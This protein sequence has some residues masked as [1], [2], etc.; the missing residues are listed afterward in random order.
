MLMMWTAAGESES[1]PPTSHHCETNLL[2]NPAMMSSKCNMHCLSLRTQV[3]LSSNQPVVDTQ[4]HLYAQLHVPGLVRHSCTRICTQ[5]CT[6]AVTFM[7]KHTQTRP[8]PHTQT[9]QQCVQ[10][11]RTC[12]VQAPLFTGKDLAFHK[13]PSVCLCKLPGCANSTW[14]LVSESTLCQS[15]GPSHSAQVVDK[16]G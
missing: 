10:K 7:Q 4:L 3:Q 6:H 12:C 5:A 16:T 9:H 1:L 14:A 2:H 8:L 11:A 15:V 13:H